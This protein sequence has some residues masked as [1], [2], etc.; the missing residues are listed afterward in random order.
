MINLDKSIDSQHLTIESNHIESTFRV[1]HLSDVH[2]PRPDVPLTL[3]VKTIA[4]LHPDVI[5]V[6]GDLFDCRATPKDVDVINSFLLQLNSIGKLLWVRGNHE[7]KNRYSKEILDK[8]VIQPLMN[9]YIQVRDD[10]EVLG[11]DE[12]ARYVRSQNKSGRL[13]LVLSHHPESYSYHLTGPHC[14]QFSGH[15]HGG[16]VRVGN[17][18]LFGPDQGVLLKYSK[19]YYPMGNQSGLIVCAG[20]GRSIFPMRIN[21]PSHIVVVDFIP[22]GYNK[23]SEVSV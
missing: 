21:N 12:T 9:E 8:L 11:V 6:T 17:Q 23:K 18:G 10:I 4:R 22:V 7:L 16:Q 5:F 13:T 3:I 19:G 2:I 15:V 14:F 1:L 20:L